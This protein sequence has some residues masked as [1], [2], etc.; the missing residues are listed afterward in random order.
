MELITAPE[1]GNEFVFLQTSSTLNKHK[2]TKKRFSEFETSHKIPGHREKRD[3]PAPHPAGAIKLDPLKLIEKYKSQLATTSTT[4]AKPTTKATRRGN[5]KKRVKKEAA[6]EG[7]T[8]PTPVLTTGK[9]SPVEE[10]VGSASEKQKSRIQIK[11]GPNGQE[12]EYEY[13]YYYYDDEEDD[14]KKKD[15]KVTNAHDG[16]AK[17]ETPKG[18]KTG[19]TEA[20]LG[21]NEIVPASRNPQRS[22]GRQLSLEEEVG[23]ERLPANTRFPPRSRNLGTTPVPEEEP[24]TTRK[25]RTRQTTEA[26]EATTEE[27]AARVSTGLSND[28]FLKCRFQG[29]NKGRTRANVRRPSLELVDSASFNTHSGS[30]N[31]DAVPAFPSDLPS[32]PVRF[33]GAT[34]NEKPTEAPVESS[35]TT[36]TEPPVTMNQMDKVALDLYAVVQGTQKLSGENEVSIPQFAV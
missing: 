2:D 14:K 13:V 29:S 24:K 5:L 18:G 32:G 9:S 4:T 27:L 28:N 11:K 16:P 1:P 7:V 25:S 15:E 20:E 35:T 31:S 26:P 30:T 21:I 36:S 3:A 34:P 22:R 10:V 6:Y 12:Y 19:K 23:E 33:L 8:H 17:E